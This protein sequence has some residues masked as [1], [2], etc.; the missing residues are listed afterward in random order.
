MTF[1]S[2]IGYAGRMS[3]APLIIGL[4][5]GTSC[6]GIDA[7]IVRMSRR[8]EL[9]VFRA[10]PLDARLREAAL[11][12]TEPG[13]DEIDAMGEL[14]RA[15][16]LA[17]AGAARQ[18]IADAQLTCGDIAAIG[19]HGQT[20]RHR[21]RARYPFTLQIGCTATIAEQTGIT[22]VGDFRRRDIAAGGC[23]APLVPFAH[24][25]LFA[26][27]G[28]NI[29]VLNIGGI[30]NITWLGEDGATTGFD[31]GP[32]NMLMDAL[33]LTLSDGR[34]AFDKNG[35]LAAAG[36]VCAPLLDALMQH[37]FLSRRPPKSTGREEFG[38]DVRDTILGW[39]D[40]SDADRL[41][42]AAAFT[43]ACVAE[44]RSWLPAAPDRWIVC[45]GGAFNLHLLALLGDALKPAPLLTSTGAGLPPEAVEAVSFAVLAARTL[46]GMNNTV[47]AVTGAGRAVCGGSIVPGDNWSELL[48]SIPQWIR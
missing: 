35:E 14:D 29:A 4:M 36:K 41:A 17:F 23:G 30:A 7:A 21:P 20:I 8:P 43:V 6:D 48:T 24:R 47:P 13:I 5:S 31:V 32:G 33:M 28:E 45:G 40:I 39:P 16:G 38:S 12:L 22:T 25:A 37:P 46:A 19:S 1:P 18:V 34:R 15:L 27:P 11:R 42:T 10:C 9:L 26:H 44:A 2:R 3:E